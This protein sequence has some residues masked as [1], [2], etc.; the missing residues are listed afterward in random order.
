MNCFGYLF[1]FVT[2]RARLRSRQSPD[3][4]SIAKC[5]QSATAAAVKAS[6]SE[7]ET[8]SLLGLQHMVSKSKQQPC[9]T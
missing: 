9:G 2:L 5:L 8:Q 7:D 1:I 3:M 6:G 4:H